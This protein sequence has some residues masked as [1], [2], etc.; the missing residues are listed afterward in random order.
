[1]TTSPATLLQ[2]IVGLAA[3]PTLHAR[4]Y[5]RSRSTH[6]NCKEDGH[7]DDALT[8]VSNSRTKVERELKAGKG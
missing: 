4:H 7:E 3:Y 6:G 2:R 5:C 1:M 8:K